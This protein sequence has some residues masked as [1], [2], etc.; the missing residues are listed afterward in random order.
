LQDSHWPAHPPLQHT[1]STQFPFRHWFEALQ[2]P[3][4]ASFGAQLVPLQ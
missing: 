1:P 4:S 2:V 3:P